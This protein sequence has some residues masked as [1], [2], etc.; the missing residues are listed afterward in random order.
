[1]ESLHMS[2]TEFADYV[3]LSAATLSSIYTGRT[4]PTLA[5]VESIK[6]KLP[7]INLS[8]LLFGEGQMQQKENVTA[9]PTTDNS[10]SRFQAVLNFDDYPAQDTPTPSVNTPSQRRADNTNITPRERAREEVKNFDKIGRRVIEI[11][12]FYDDQTWDTFVPAK[13]K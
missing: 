2:Q 11:R 7:D 13:P 6:Q 8:W 3:G 12:V 4:R 5:T 10:A 1:M 9:T